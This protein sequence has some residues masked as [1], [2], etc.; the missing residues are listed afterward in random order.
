MPM[1][2][3]TTFEPHQNTT[4]HLSQDAEDAPSLDLELI[5]VTDK[6]PEGFEGEQFSL[7]FKGPPDTP[8]YQQTYT[9]AHDEMGELALFLVPVG[10]EDDGM[11]YE[12]FFNHTADAA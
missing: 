3:R 1:L 2:T 9:L 7:V 5:E 6:T 11:L 12:A 4:F 10:K 8:L